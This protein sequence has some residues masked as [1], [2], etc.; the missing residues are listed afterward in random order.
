MGDRKDHKTWRDEPFL[1]ACAIAVVFFLVMFVGVV[2]LVGAGD[3]D[4][5]P[6]ALWMLAPAAIIAFAAAI[7]APTRRL[8]GGMFYLG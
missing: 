2:A 5:R 6:A 7:Y 4:P 1:T 3:V 8:F